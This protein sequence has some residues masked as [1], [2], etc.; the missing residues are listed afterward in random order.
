MARRGGVAGHVWRNRHDDGIL[1][2]DNRFRGRRLGTAIR[3]AVL[4]SGSVMRKPVWLACAV[5]LLGT[6]GVVGTLELRSGPSQGFPFRT[7]GI[8]GLLVEL[9]YVNDNGNPRWVGRE[10]VRFEVS[11]A[12]RSTK[13]AQLIRQSLAGETHKSAQIGW[14]K[15][16]YAD[17]ATTVVGLLPG[18]SSDYYELQPPGYGTRTVSRGVFFDVMK[19]AGI[20]PGVLPRITRQ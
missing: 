15:F 16:R 20:D 17:G 14:L 7:E 5:L 12:P 8:Q 9:V 1:W 11:D 10:P 19:G 6:S 3:L 18:H 4:Q 13:V 2:H